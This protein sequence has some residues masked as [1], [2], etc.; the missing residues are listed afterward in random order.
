METLI[1]S[2]RVAFVSG[3]SLPASS[4][5][6]ISRIILPILCVSLGVS[7]G[8]AT[9]LTLALINASNH[10]VVASSD[11]VE[12]SAAPSADLAANSSPAQATQAAVAG[13]TIATPSTLAAN[14]AANPTVELRPAKLIPATTSVARSATAPTKVE[15]ALNKT[16]DAL[17]PATFKMEGKTYHVAKMMFL[18]AAK[19]GLQEPPAPQ[20]APPTALNTAQWSLDTPA[21]ASLY[22]EGVLTVSDYNASTGTIQTSDGRTFALGTTVASGNATSWESYRSDVHYRCDQNG[23]CVLM[24]AGVV[25]P[26]AKLI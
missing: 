13:P 15:V 1:E 4:P 18:P 8:T 25:A 19:P 17:K 21:P 12:S 10:S 23:S 16:P 20:P 3:A 11:S 9:G 5:F 22:T 14:T 24:R 2:P 6:S 7:V 26:D